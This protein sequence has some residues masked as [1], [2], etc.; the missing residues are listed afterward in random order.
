MT[1]RR[2]RTRK[3]GRLLLPRQERFE[4]ESLLH[5]R[6]PRAPI[7]VSSLSLSIY[8]S[9]YLSVYLFS[10]SLS[11][12]VFVSFCL[13]FEAIRVPFDSPLSVIVLLLLVFA[14]VPSL[15][16]SATMCRTS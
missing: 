5:H 9:I 2:T 16:C 15:P 3:E 12:S 10:L 4:P 13:V 1:Q 8:L 7:D 6:F 14:Q 11:L